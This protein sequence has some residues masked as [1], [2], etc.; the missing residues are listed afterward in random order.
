MNFLLV[1]R[2][3]AHTSTGVAPCVLFLKRDMRTRLHL[4]RPEVKDHVT[5]QQASQKAHHD[6]H[7][8]AR[9]L[10]VGQRVLVRNYRP[11]ENWIPGTVVDRRGPLSYTVRIADGQLLHRHIDQLKE[12]KDSPQEDVSKNSSDIDTHAYESGPTEAN[13][14]ELELIDTPSAHESGGTR[15][16]SSDVTSQSD[17]YPKRNRKPPDRLTY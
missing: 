17:R 3:T 7:S 6:Q 11:G 1:Y 4:L 8:R 10:C 9:E 16:I 5:A 14:S 12:M 15:E 13:A 2:T